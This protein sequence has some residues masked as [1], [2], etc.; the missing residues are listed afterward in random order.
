MLSKKFF[1]LINFINLIYLVSFVNVKHI[2]TFQNLGVTTIV[3]VS[4]NGN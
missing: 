1:K 2:I 3:F 4:S